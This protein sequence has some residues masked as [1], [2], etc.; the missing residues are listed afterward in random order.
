MSQVTKTFIRKL[1]SVFPSLSLADLTKPQTPEANMTPSFVIIRVTNK[2][3]MTREHIT[4]T[5]G[6]VCGMQGDLR[7]LHCL[8]SCHTKQ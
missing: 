3:R 8:S 5:S 4:E 2:K 7:Y 1:I 6:E